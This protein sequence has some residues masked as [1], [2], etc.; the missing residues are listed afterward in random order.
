LTTLT[1]ISLFLRTTVKTGHHYP[2][3]SPMKWP[4]HENILYA[5][6]YRGVY[7]SAD[8]GQSWA[9][10]GPEMAAT[11]ISDLV[12]Q[13]KEMDLVAGTH[14]R[15][16][17]KMNVTPIQ[18]AFQQGN[19]QKNILFKTP[20][21]TLPWFN[22]THNDPRQKSMEKIPITFYL[23]KEEDLVT[24]TV[25][26]PQPYFIHYLKFPKPGTYDLFVTGK[27]VALNGELTIVEHPS[28][29]SSLCP[30]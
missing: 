9:L 28:I 2:Q 21:A 18:S 26:S 1:I 27:D 3:I 8:R 29:P 10:L 16:I 17:Y 23:I 24:E 25:D 22:D 20:A 6:L 7:L 14:G 11:C 5:G 30:S 4:I 12:I 13:E 15:G 19:P